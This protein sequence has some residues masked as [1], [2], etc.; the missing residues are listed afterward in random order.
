VTLLVRRR[1]VIGL[2]LYPMMLGICVRLPI[3]ARCCVVALF[4]LI[5][6]VMVRIAIIRMVSG[7]N[8]V[9]IRVRVVLGFDFG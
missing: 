6:S 4:W 2:Q 3:G 9:K 7:R 5:F 1:D 8:K